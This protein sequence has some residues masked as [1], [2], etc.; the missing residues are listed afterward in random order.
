MF[1]TYILVKCK[2]TSTKYAII[3]YDKDLKVAIFCSKVDMLVN[4]GSFLCRITCHTTKCDNSNVSSR[5]GFFVF[6]AIF[7]KVYLDLETVD[8]ETVEF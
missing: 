2:K 1:F 3:K 6:T 4:F 5:S 7:S 8:L